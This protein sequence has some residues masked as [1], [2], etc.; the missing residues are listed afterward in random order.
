MPDMADQQSREDLVAEIEELR[1][2][3]L[4]SEETLRAIR[5]GEVDA[6]LVSGEDGDRIFTLKGAESPYRLAAT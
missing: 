1:E 3:L 4:E 2:R 5:E 6:L